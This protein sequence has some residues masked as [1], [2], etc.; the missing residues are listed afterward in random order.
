M[1]H[2]VTLTLRFILELCAVACLAYWGYQAAD[3]PVVR[4]LFAVAAAALF[5]LGWS[6]FL[7][8]TASSGLGH[9]Q[10]DVIGGAVMLLAA[11][12]LA[13]TGQHRAALILGVAIV[14]DSALLLALRD[15]PLPAVFGGPRA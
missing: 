3:Q 10:K 4:L 7:A 1:L 6:V 11:M 2:I 9:V 15:Q 14:V 13:A 12:A 8:P 5:V